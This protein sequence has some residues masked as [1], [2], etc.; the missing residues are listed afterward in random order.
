MCIFYKAWGRF[1]SALY[2]ASQHPDLPPAP[3]PPFP[4]QLAMCRLASPGG[5]ASLHM[6]SWEGK[7]GGYVIGAQD[8]A[9][10]LLPRS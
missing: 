7:G 4:S 10:R 6:A 3:P 8:Y 9:A 1:V 2:L 5:W